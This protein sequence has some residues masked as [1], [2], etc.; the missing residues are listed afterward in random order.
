MKFK[1]R[2]R[3]ESARLRLWD[4]T[5]PGWYFV[6]VCTKQFN[7][8]FGKIDHGGIIMN[9][10]GQTAN[11]YWADIPEHHDNTAI[12]EFIVMPNHIH[13]IIIIAETLGV[14]TSHVETLHATSLP[15]PTRPS[16]SPPKGSLGVIV[17][18]FKSVVTR[19]A[20]MNGYPNF[21]WQP[22]FFDHIIRNEDALSQIRIYI[23]NNPQK[24][25][26]DKY[27]R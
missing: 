8:Y 15:S 19:W 21:A 6:T 18:S 17:R 16:I 4:Y 26:N 27:F 23:Q 2:Y 3:I 5:S 12:D 7:I 9:D 10:L 24:W 11:Q 14:D 22:R 13:G 25:E 1:S 20:R